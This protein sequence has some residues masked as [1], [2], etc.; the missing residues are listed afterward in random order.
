M[1]DLVTKDDL[2]RARHDPEFRQQLLVEN[3][4]RLLEAL[5]KMRKSSDIKPDAAR[6][7]RE[8]VD[9]AVKLADR[10]QQNAHENAHGGPRAA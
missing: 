8:G 3:L 9:L 5:N 6:Q 10:L 7:I 4:D 2:A 1:S